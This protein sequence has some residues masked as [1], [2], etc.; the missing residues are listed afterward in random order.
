MI[1]IAPPDP[2]WPA[3]AGAEMT[4]WRRSMGDR[5]LEIHHIGSTSVPGL[6]AKPII[7]L[8]PIFPDPATLDSARDAVEAMGYD[9][10]GETGIP[11][12]RYCRRSDPETGARLVHAHGFPEGHPGIAQ[13]LSFRDWLAAHPAARK[14]YVA[15]KT[16]CAAQHPESGLAYSGCKSAW[17]SDAV[18]RA[19][20]WVEAAT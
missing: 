1:R 15:V 18:E 8:L 14:D 4:T 2:D 11:G 19:M 5:M 20:A 3:R 17:I 6:P 9:W 12:R 16:R 7:D 13:H 10:K